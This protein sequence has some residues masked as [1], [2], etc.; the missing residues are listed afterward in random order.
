[1]GGGCRARVGHRGGGKH[2]GRPLFTSEPTHRQPR[3]PLSPGHREGGSGGPVH[4]GP[5][6]RHKPHT[7]VNRTQ[8]ALRLVGLASS[9]RRRV[10]RFALYADDRHAGPP[11][12]QRR[13]R[14]R[15][16]GLGVRAAPLAV[17]S[18][19]DDGSACRRGSARAVL[20]DE[21][22]R[23]SSLHGRRFAAHLGVR[24]VA[25]PEPADQWTVLAQPG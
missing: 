14:A 4:A 20:S 22:E 2:T 16:G 6:W 17:H 5:R 25:S 12:R 10:E 23:L 21:G 1:M 18:T 13:L 11:G 19:P 3:A 9:R 7:D 15:S 8:C 24:R